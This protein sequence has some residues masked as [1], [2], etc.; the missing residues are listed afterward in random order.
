MGIQVRV[1]ACLSPGWW[2]VI[3][4][5]GFGMLDGGSEQVWPDAW[6]PAKARRPNSEFHITGFVG[7]V[8]QFVAE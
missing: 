5:P 3:I 8:P 7:G 2:R 4:G 6:V 1:I